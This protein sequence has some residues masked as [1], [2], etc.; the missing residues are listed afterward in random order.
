MEVF[1]ENKTLAAA[2]DPYRKSKKI[3][4]VPTM[5]ALHKGHLSLV[6]IGL[7]N[8]DL[9]VV[10]IFVNPTQFNNQGDLINYPRTLQKDVTLLKTLQANVVV[11][12][13]EAK[14]LYG[15]KIIS[16]KYNFGAIAREM[17]GKHRQG[18]FDGVGTVVGLLFKAVQPNTAYFGEKD[19]QQ[20]QIVKKMTAIEKLPV[21]IIGCPI[22]REPSNLA[23]S[24]RNKRLNPQQL[25]AAVIIHKSLKLVA[26]HFQEKSISQLNKMVANCFEDSSLRLEYFE[27]ANEKTLKTVQRKRKGV[28][29]RCFI[30]AFVGEVRLIDNHKLN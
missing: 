27:I 12:A 1:T 22:V 10:S 3:G 28:S 15:N 7:K 2:L 16:K 20:L 23:M 26:E 14:E 19:F 9:V 17:E 18:H 21:E 4:L 5:G 11:Y 25:K 13:P 24:S 30:A 6:S 29:Y 8:N